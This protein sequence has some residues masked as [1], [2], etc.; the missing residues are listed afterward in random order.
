MLRLTY[1]DQTLHTWFINERYTNRVTK[2][3][4]RNNVFDRKYEK[5][6]MMH[7]IRRFIVLTEL[8]VRINTNV[9]QII[10]SGLQ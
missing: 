5:H 2:V 9:K 4:F 6:A 7:Y 3:Q 1:F 10:V 8:S